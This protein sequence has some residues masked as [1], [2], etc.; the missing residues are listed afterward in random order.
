MSAQELRDRRASLR[1]ACCFEELEELSASPDGEIF[2]GV[3]D[4]VGVL[5][6]SVMVWEMETD[7]DASRVGAG[8]CVWDLGKA[9]GGGEADGYRGGV[10]EVMGFGEGG[11]FGSGCECACEKVAAG[12]G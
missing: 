2:G 6:T 4:D 1:S 12:V 9:G 5:P 10:V 3:G 7:G 8:V 11:C